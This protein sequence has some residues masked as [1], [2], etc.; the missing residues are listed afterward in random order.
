MFK[1]LKVKHRMSWL[2]CANSAAIYMIKR[3]QVEI[4]MNLRIPMTTTTQLRHIQV[5]RRFRFIQ[6]SKL[7]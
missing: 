1:T 4:K 7:R 3:T 2:L 6:E 5:L